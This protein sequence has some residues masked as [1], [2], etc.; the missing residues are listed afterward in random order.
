MRA[1]VHFNTVVTR[2]GFDYGIRLGKTPVAIQADNGRGKAMLGLAFA[3]QA[4]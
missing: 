4:Y 1:R 3:M 2:P